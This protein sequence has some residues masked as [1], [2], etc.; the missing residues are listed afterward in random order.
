MKER[1]IVDLITCQQSASD[2]LMGRLIGKHNGA[3]NLQHMCRECN[4][5]SAETLPENL[6]GEELHSQRLN[7]RKEVFSP[8][9]PTHMQSMMEG[10]DARNFSHLMNQLALGWPSD[11]RVAW[12]PSNPVQ[13]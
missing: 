9:K 7:S 6:P 12:L 8:S 11:S 10:V 5:E 2:L 1:I 4:N 3:G 13:I